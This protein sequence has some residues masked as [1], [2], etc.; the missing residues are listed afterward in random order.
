LAS[1]L[2][3]ATSFAT[4]AAVSSASP[5]TIVTDMPPE[6]SAFRTILVSLRTRHENAMKPANLNGLS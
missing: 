6:L 2:Q 4:C 3:I 5:V 1:S